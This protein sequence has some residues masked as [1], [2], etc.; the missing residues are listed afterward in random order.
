MIAAKTLTA[1]AY[2]R[3]DG[4][5]KQRAQ[6]E[7]AIAA[8]IPRI[9]EHVTDSI[10]AAN[11]LAQATGAQIDGDEDLQ[12]LIDRAKDDPRTVGVLALM[13]TI[14]ALR[15]DTHDL[16]DAPRKAAAAHGATGGK[17]GGKMAAAGNKKPNGLTHIMD[18]R[19]SRFEALKALGMD[20]GKVLKQIARED[21][22][23][24]EAVRQ[25]L[26]SAG[27]PVSTKDRQGRRR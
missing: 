15:R 26:K 13:G 27:V 14:Q 7:E 4:T 10:E 17:I 16:K 8:L 6:F 21:G 18:R 2:M 11:A 20:D 25:S 3:G 23:S 5:R 1:A 22:C 9:G 12:M 19:K 24:P